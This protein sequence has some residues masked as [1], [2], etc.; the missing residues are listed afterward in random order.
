V[1]Y[2]DHGKLLIQLVRHYFMVVHGNIRTNKG[3][4]DLRRH[5]VNKL[6]RGKL[7]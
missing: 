5:L 2:K 3:W 4:I 6:D 7:I 1:Q